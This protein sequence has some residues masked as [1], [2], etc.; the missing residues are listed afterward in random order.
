MLNKLILFN[1][2]GFSTIAFIK[3]FP[4]ISM[5]SFLSSL[6]CSSFLKS[7]PITNE[8][9]DR[10]SSSKTSNAAI[11]TFEPK[12]LPPNVEPCVPKSMRHHT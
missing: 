3:P 1:I 9:S 8:F 11:A 12:G 5:M 6:L 10:F 7:C 2:L 4:R